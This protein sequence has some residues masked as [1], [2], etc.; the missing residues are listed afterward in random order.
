MICVTSCAKGSETRSRCSELNT[1]A[2]VMRITSQNTPSAMPDSTPTFWPVL[3]SMR[4]STFSR[5]S[6]RRVPARST[7]ANSQPTAMMTS[8]MKIAGSCSPSVDCNE[9]ERTEKSIFVTSPEEVGL[10]KSRISPC[11][12]LPALHP[13]PDRVQRQDGEP[14]E[15][16]LGDGKPEEG[17]FYFRA[18]P[19]AHEQLLQHAAEREVLHHEKQVRTAGRY[20]IRR[21][22]LQPD[23]PRGD[24]ESAR[25]EQ[26]CGTAVDAS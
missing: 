24:A 12:V 10:P 25:G 14:R 23:L 4:W 20:L 2:T 13:Q 9:V 3:S 6:S 7:S 5:P 8:E 26:E 21:Q 18:L 15:R 1:A 19:G 11:R 22:M 17:P 16:P